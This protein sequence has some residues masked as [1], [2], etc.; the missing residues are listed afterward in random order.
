PVKEVEQEVQLAADAIVDFQPDVVHQVVSENKRKKGMFEGLFLEGR[1]PLNVGVTSSGDFFGG[2]Q[3]A[4]TDV[5][6]DQNFLFTAVSIRELRS[7]DGTYINLAKRLHYGLS[8]FDTTRF[9]FVSPYALQPGF[10]REGAFAIHHYTVAT[11]SAQ[12]PLDKFRRL[13]L[14]AGVVRIN[15]QFENPAVEEFV[16]QRAESLGVPYILH[17]GT[18]VPLGVALVAETT[19]FREFGPLSG[20][21][22][23]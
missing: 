7:Y 5:L 18:T 13:D 16:R 19:R 2:T 23:S 4:L 17:K 6:G 12:Y 1:P 22:Y 14:S 8:A 10:S 3:V 11:A 21:T 20:H 15:E 9:F